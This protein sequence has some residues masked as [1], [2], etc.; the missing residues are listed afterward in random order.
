M[1]QDFWWS[2]RVQISKTEIT[3]EG[4]SLRSMANYIV[5]IMASDT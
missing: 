5:K 2:G 3:W 1:V 4:V